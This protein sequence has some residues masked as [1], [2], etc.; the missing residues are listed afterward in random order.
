MRLLTGISQLV[1]PPGPGPRSGKAM[2]D[3]RIFT[4]AALAIDGTRIAWIGPSDSRL[5][6]SESWRGRADEVSDLHGCAVVPGLVDPHTHAIWAG[7]RLADFEARCAGA[8]YEQILAAG[9]GIWHSIRQTA[10]KSAHE[11]AALALP[12]IQA[13]VRSGATTIEIKSGYGYEPEAELRMLEAIQLLRAKTPARL[14]PT[15]LIHVAPADSNERAALVSRI[16][17]E[18]IPQ[19][20]ERHLAGSVDIF[21]EQHAW[22]A[23]DART[24]LTA[25]RHQGLP[26]R[27]HTEQFSSIGGLELGLELH[28]L[29]VDHLEVCSASQCAAIARSTTVATILPG[30]SL[31]LGLQP[32]P[33][34]ALIDAGAAVAIGTDLNPGSSPLFSASMALALAT[35]L[36]GLTAAEAL[37]AATA[38]AATALGC[39]DAGHLTRGAPADFLVLDSSD[40]RDLAFTLGPSPIREVWIGGVRA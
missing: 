6:A 17:R 19:A 20:A 11:L 35:R 38:N 12:R 10:A 32:A 18:L 23:A 7:D 22:S 33:G 27:L 39:S 15:L 37:T 14:I 4:D 24:I 40:W 3:L 34:R 21:V 9:G 25:A 16:C 28:A 5:G 1:T 30:V 26:V 31:H 13:L 29:S 8:S 36:N 2:S